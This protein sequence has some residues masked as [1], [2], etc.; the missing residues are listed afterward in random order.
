MFA[1]VLPDGLEIAKWFKLMQSP[2]QL[3]HSIVSSDGDGEW[4]LS[5][6]RSINSSI[7]LKLLAAYGLYLRELETFVIS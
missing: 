7:I 6:S 5:Y 4:L 3:D 1:D 2:V